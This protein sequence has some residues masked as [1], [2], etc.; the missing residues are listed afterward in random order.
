MIAVILVCHR[1]PCNPHQTLKVLCYLSGTEH[2]LRSW[3]YCGGPNSGHL[4]LSL[5]V[6]LIVLWPFWIGLMVLSILQWISYFPEFPEHTLLVLTPM[7]S[8]YCLQCFSWSPGGPYISMGTF[9][10]FWYHWWC[11][12]HLDCIAVFVRDACFHLHFLVFLKFHANL[13]MH[14]CF[15]ESLVYKD[16]KCMARGFPGKPE[17]HPIWWVSSHDYDSHPVF[18][19]TFWISWWLEV[20]RK[21][22]SIYW[23]IVG[24]H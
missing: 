14:C 24:L 8:L 19:V 4:I 2:S 11:F 12:S 21:E 1:T 23:T 6:S 5:I 7:D 9:P 13:S 20:H 18:L 10:A 15:W 16:S 17:K 22:L 3:V